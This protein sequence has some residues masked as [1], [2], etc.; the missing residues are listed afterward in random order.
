MW[1]KLSPVS[2]LTLATLLLVG[3]C[4]KD[5]EQKAFPRNED[6]TKSLETST[7]EAEDA[8]YSIISEPEKL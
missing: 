8:P 3:G 5:L 7:T 2:I 1:F 4:T 6:A